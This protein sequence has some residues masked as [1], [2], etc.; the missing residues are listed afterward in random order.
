M[1][2]FGEL[3][4]SETEPSLGRSFYRKKLGHKGSYY[5]ISGLE[6]KSGDEFLEDL[7][8]KLREAY[9]HGIHFSGYLSLY[10]ADLNFVCAVQV[11]S[12]N[13]SIKGWS[14]GDLLDRAIDLSLNDF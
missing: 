6:G 13:V 2:V 10:D 3:F 12:E 11:F 5:K 8:E 14:E 9:H 7:I 1:K 4:S